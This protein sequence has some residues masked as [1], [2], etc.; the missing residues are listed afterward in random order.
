[1]FDFDVLQ[2]VK[3]LVQ[4][5]VGLL[6]K[7]TA[8]QDSLLDVRNQIIVLATDSEQN[9]I[10]VFETL[11]ELQSRIDNMETKSWHNFAILSQ[12][13]KKAADTVKPKM[14]EKIEQT[15]E[16]WKQYITN[17]DV[18]K[19]AKDSRSKKL[20]G[21]TIEQGSDVRMNEHK[22]QKHMQC[23]QS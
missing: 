20:E 1:M 10:N 22:Q 3:E 13:L 17:A 9:D 21:G 23:Y 15:F 6:K 2:K 8:S 5:A 14:S 7:K 16:R 11:L 12:A 18:L 4:T 19:L